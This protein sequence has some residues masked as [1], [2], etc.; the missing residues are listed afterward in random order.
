MEENTFEEKL[1]KPTFDD[2]KPAIEIQLKNKKAQILF[3]I[4]VRLS[5][6]PASST[7]SSSSASSKLAPLERPKMMP[8]KL[9]NSPKSCE[10]TRRQ[11]EIYWQPN[12]SCGKL[13]LG[14]FIGT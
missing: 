4:L 7:S 14:G 9:P 13:K 1:T 6:R 12:F 11:D 10:Q 3:S 8:K 5:Q 2:S